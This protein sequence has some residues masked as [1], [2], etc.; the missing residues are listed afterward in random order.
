MDCIV[1]AQLWT[2][3]RSIVDKISSSES[4]P[5]FTTR[6]RIPTGYR[7]NDFPAKIVMDGNFLPQA[8]NL[9]S[10]ITISEKHH[11]VL[12]TRTLWAFACLLTITGSMSMDLAHFLLSP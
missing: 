8:H 4:I 3:R 12:K 10:Q 9:F 1:Y 2:K 5:A 11:Q 7:L 6:Q